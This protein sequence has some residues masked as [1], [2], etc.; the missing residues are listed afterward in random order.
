MIFWQSK[1]FSRVFSSTVV[2]RHQ[3]FGTR[4]FFIVQLSQLYMT[5]G[6]TIILTKW[7]FV[8]KIMFLLF[9]MLSR[10]VIALPVKAGELVLFNSWKFIVHL[11][12]M[13]LSVCRPSF[14]RLWLRYNWHIT[15]YSLQVYNIMIQCVY[16]LQN[17]TIY[18]YIARPDNKSI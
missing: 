5:T 7:T 13:Q 18:I 6:K 12:F 8:G 3:F 11:S 1:G 10:F 2:W 14:R 17:I 15:L 4:P 16:I 9:N